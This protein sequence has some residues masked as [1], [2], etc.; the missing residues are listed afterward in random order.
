SF[1]PAKM[2]SDKKNISIFPL[3]S[4]SSGLPAHRPYYTKLKDYPLIDRKETL[5]QW[6]LAEKRA[7]PPGT[8]HLYSDLGFI[9]LGYIIEKVSGTNLDSYWLKNIAQPLHVEKYF[10]FPQRNTGCKGNFVTTGVCP[11]SKK[12]LHGLVHDDNCRAMGGIAGHA[13]LFGTSEGILLLCENILLQEKG[14]LSHPSYDNKI[15]KTVFKRLPSTTWCLGFDSPSENSS[16]S[17]KYFSKKSRGH[18][19]FTGTSFWIDPENKI[20]IVFLTNRVLLSK[21]EGIQKIR[22]L[23]HVIGMEELLF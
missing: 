10:C 3:L 18:L 15:W 22:P 14:I 7:Y 23:I 11:W 21:K 17:G 16:S 12:K 4:H 2:L 1:F 9:L 19:G 6:I 8:Q 5:I 20:C 13:G